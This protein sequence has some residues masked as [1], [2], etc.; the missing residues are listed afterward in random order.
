MAGLILPEGMAIQSAV[1]RTYAWQFTTFSN[2]P[3]NVYS[4]TSDWN[5]TGATWDTR[6]GTRSWASS[7][8]SGIDRTSLLDSQTISTTG[9]DWFEV[10]ASAETMRVT[11]LG[12]WQIGA[13]INLER[14]LR[15]GDELS[16]AASAG[17]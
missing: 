16:R 17:H 6:D 8:A 5:E 7:G 4:G 10:A 15:L 2:V 13:S 1:L 14:A 12:D 9:D 3:I 11:T